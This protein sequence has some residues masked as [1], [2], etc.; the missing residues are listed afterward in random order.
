MS[1]VL[2]NFLQRLTSR[3]FLVACAAYSIVLLAGLDVVEFDR[4]VVATATAALIAYLGVEGASDLK[5]R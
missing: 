3:K 1:G 2:T 4:E 5:G